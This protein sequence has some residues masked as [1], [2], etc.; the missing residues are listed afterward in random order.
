MGACWGGFSQNKSRISRN[1]R[2][3][4]KLHCSNIRV[5]GGV[6]QFVI[7]AVVL[8]FGLERVTHGGYVVTML[9]TSG[10]K[11]EQMIVG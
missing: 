4:I 8:T 7:F 3:E 9:L 11:Y 1:F 10:Y 2:V 5:S 6:Y